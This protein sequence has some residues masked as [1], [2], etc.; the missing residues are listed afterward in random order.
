[1]AA[2]TSCSD[3]GAPKSKVSH[4]FRCFPHLFSMKGWDQWWRHLWLKTKHR[5]M[6]VTNRS[7]STITIAMITIWL[8]GTGSGEGRGRGHRSPLILISR[9]KGE[10][11]STYHPSTHPRASCCHSALQ[12]WVAKAEKRTGIQ[13]SS[14]PLWDHEGRWTQMVP[15]PWAARPHGLDRGVVQAKPLPGGRWGSFGQTLWR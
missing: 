7:S 13:A 12:G 1:M 3:F 15:L 14:R 10:Y 5:R 9:L 6:N 11:L 4:C 8:L 2:I